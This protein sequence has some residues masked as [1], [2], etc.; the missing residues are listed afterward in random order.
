VDRKI[1]DRLRQL[2]KEEIAHPREDLG[3]NI[4]DAEFPIL[5]GYEGQSEI[6]YD[7]QG[8]DDILDDITSR[9][10][11]YS[12]DSLADVEVRDLPVGIGIEL[13][14]SSRSLLKKR[15]SKMIREQSE[16]PNRLDSLIAFLEDL[17]MKLQDTHTSIEAEAMAVED[18]GLSDDPEFMEMVDQALEILWGAMQEISDI[19]EQ[20]GRDGLFTKE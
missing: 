14:E 20:M 17:P 3:K 8:L 18:E 12:L 7:Q 4:A 11:A 16:Q 1:R 2:I 19:T 6:A 15:L 10:I 9:G 13:M 5:V